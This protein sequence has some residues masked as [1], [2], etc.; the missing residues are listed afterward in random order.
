MMR[1]DNRTADREAHAHSCRTG[2]EICVKNPVEP[3][4]SDP[5]S[6]VRHAKLNTTAGVRKCFHNNSWGKGLRNGKGVEGVAKEIH[7]N[8]LDLHRI[9]CGTWQVACQV[10]RE[11][12]TAALDFVT[13]E[14]RDVED[15]L[16][17]I[18]RFEH[19]FLAGDEPADPLDDRAGAEGWWQGCVASAL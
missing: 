3:L 1:F 10:E 17:G 14:L 16:V 18:E 9:A 5:L 12:H 11:G 7:Q 8:L 15:E 6:V 2:A 13:E 19:R 4:L